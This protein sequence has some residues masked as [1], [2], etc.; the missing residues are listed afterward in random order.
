MVA[1]NVDVLIK[2]AGVY[3]DEGLAILTLSRVRLQ[4]SGNTLFVNSN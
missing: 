3:P 4:G 1:V 2:N